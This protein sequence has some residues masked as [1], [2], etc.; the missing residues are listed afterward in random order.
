SLHRQLGE[1]LP[2]HMMPAE[3]VV[4]EQMPWLPNF[5]IDRQRLAQIDAERL[6]ARPAV[7]S[8]P[9]LGEVIETFRQ[10]TKSAQASPTDN[11][12]TLGGDS[13]LALEL[14]LEIGRRFKV[15]VPVQ[16]QDPTRTVAQWAHDI[17]AW[18][19]LDAAHCAG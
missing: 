7:D 18:R 11:L 3:I 2:P 17:A 4:V 9:L 10:L 14:M 8:S 1:R 6:S 15:V 5:K 13:L 16:A 19:E 12:L